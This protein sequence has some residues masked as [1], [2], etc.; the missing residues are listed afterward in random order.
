[1]DQKDR[2]ADNKTVGDK[3]QA[4]KKPYEKPSFRFERV[5]ETSALSCGKVN[6]RQK[7]CRGGARKSS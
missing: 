4:D 3:N 6:N 2:I 1:M 5:F 7:T